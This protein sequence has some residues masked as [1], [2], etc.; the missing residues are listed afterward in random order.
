MLASSVQAVVACNAT[1]PRV[2]TLVLLIII[3][4]HDVCTTPDS[5]RN[6]VEYN[7]MYIST[8]SS[9]SIHVHKR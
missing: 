3:F 6:Y 1:E 2:C 8:T 5:V 4:D 7:V 9:G